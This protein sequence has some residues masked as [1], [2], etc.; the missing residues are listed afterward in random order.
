[1]SQ[2]SSLTTVTTH[3]GNTIPRA[4]SLRRVSITLNNYTEEELHLMV[5]TAIQK[6][7]KYIIGK[8]IGAEGTPHLQ[9]YFEFTSPIKF[10][11][12]KNYFPRC[13]IEKSKGTRLQ[14]MQYCMKDNN[15][16][17]NLP[18]K[19]DKKQLLLTTKF[20][21]ITWRPW[22]QELLDFIATTPDDRTV[23]WYCDRGGSSGKSFM[24][25]YLALMGKTIV[26]EGKKA[27]VFHK[28]VEWEADENREDFN[29]V[30]WDM[31]R[32]YRKDF[33][34]YGALEQI[35]NGFI[36]SGKYEGGEAHFQSPHLIV[37]ANEEP[38]YNKFS[39]DRWVIKF[40]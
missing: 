18:I 31:P 25:Q 23:H 37:F 26:V 7:W 6:N 11:T 14:N 16:E 35:K 20:K 29:T 5:T 34:N 22:Q 13:H 32:A 2:A 9:C 1:M 15:Y 27:D 24:T 4:C 12:V 10:R 17:T 33:V 40:L 39:A 30:I 8:E 28:I 21:D 19:R 3:G 36:I 38:D